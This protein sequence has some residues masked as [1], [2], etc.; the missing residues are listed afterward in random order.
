MQGQT[1]FPAGFGCDPTLA[2]GGTVYPRRGDARGP[3]ASPLAGHPDARPGPTCIARAPLPRRIEELE[4]QARTRRDGSVSVFWPSV[5]LGL[6]L[7]SSLY[8]LNYF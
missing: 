7:A 5:I 6:A 3:I 8:F 2:S 1:K 4:E